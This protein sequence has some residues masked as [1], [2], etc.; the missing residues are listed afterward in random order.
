[1]DTHLS[2]LGLIQTLI[3]WVMHFVP[4]LRLRASEEDEILGI[5]DAEMGEFAYDHV[6]IESEISPK[7]DANRQVTASGGAREPMHKIETVSIDTF[8]KPEQ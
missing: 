1:M 7:C 4:G 6:G 3:L 8:E 5:D 2:Y